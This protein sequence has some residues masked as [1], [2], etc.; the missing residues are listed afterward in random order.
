MFTFDD[1]LAF[2]FTHQLATLL[3]T[4]ATIYLN[5]FN[6]CTRC[7]KFRIDEHF[8]FFK[9]YVRTFFKNNILSICFGHIL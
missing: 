7:S 4:R 8:L 3:K 1:I 6:Y 9:N 2:L 5:Y